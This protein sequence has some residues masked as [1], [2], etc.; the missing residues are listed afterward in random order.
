MYQTPDGMKHAE[1]FS[2]ETPIELQMSRYR[3]VYASRPDE[4][5]T[6]EAIQREYREIT[7]LREGVE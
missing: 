4:H 1:W 5:Q 6:W 3:F 2:H 7:N